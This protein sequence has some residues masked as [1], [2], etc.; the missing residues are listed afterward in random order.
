MK[1]K[2][3]I[4]LAACLSIATLFTACKDKELVSPKGNARLQLAEG[5]FDRF[6]FP[7][8]I[9]GSMSAVLK[10]QSGT[11]TSSYYID[12]LTDSFEITTPDNFTLN[13]D[14]NLP[15]RIKEMTISINMT[16][17]EGHVTDLSIRQITF[18][19]N[20]KQVYSKKDYFVEV[21]TNFVNL[22]PIDIMF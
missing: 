15:E 2:I 8:G 7:K 6:Y 4:S 17:P 10:T 20:G 18:T 14:Y 9:K 22:P 5:K 21:D 16:I 13:F 19:N 12:R 11:D 3:Y 1:K